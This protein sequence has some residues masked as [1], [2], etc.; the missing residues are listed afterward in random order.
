MGVYGDDPDTHVLD[1][2]LQ[3][4]ILSLFISSDFPKLFNDTIKLLIECVE[5]GLG[6]M[7]GVG[8]GKIVVLYAFQKRDD[9]TIYLFEEV[10]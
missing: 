8:Q 5:T 10:E 6:A 3:I 1:D 7:L 2:G 9:F 4:L